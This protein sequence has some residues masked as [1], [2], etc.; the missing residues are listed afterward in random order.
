MIVAHDIYSETNP[1]YGT[2]ALTMFVQGFIAANRA[3]PELPVAYL[4]LPVAISGDLAAS[5]DGTNRNTGLLEWLDRSP[6]IQLGL[7]DRVNRSMEI[8]TAAVRLA[9]FTQTL[10]LVDGARLQ[11]GT[12]KLKK[13]PIAALSDDAAYGIKRA[14]RLGFWFATAGSTRS[15]FDAMGLT[16]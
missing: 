5:F 13:S 8:V 14:E 2:Y 11:A 12:Q 1:A 3:G 15:V 16:L 7:A 6:Q 9:C 4:A 10:A